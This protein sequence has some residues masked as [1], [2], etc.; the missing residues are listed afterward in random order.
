M[1]EI[2]T[3]LP[4]HGALIKNRSYRQIW[5]F[6]L[7]GK[8]Y[9]LKFYPRTR[10]KHRVHG[11]PAMKEFL[12]L[13]QLQ[14]ARIPAPR[15]ANAL[16]GYRLNG[17][18]GDALVIEG[19][20]PSI[21]FDDYL[22]D[23][24]LR[25]EPVPNRADLAFQ[26][27]DIVEKLG[28]AGLGH[29][30]LHL[31]NFLLSSGKLYLLDAYSIRPGGM[32]HK[33]VQYLGSSAGRFATRTELMRGWLRL[34]GVPP[35]PPRSPLAKRNL[36][37]FIESS[38]GENDWFGK[39]SI[40]DWHGHYFK[41]SKFARR[42]STVSGLTFSAADWQQA[43]PALWSELESNRLEK[44][45]TSPS[46]DVFAAKVQLGGAALD[47]VLKRPYKRYWYRYINE[48]G[49]GSRARR[50]WI[51]AWRLI[52]RNIPTAWP[53]LVLQKRKLGYVTDSILILERI[54]G[55]T[56]A[57]VEL[58]KIL[59][60]SDPCSC[61]APARS[62]ERSMPPGSRTLMPRQATGSSNPIRS[63]GRGPSSSTST[64]F[65]PAA[66]SRWASNACSAPC[67][68]ISNIPRRIRSHCAKG[69]HPI[70]GR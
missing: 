63:W 4:R 30:D 18:I 60:I 5:R 45:K 29:A 22:S 3:D 28:R 35:L 47:V 23:L 32:R 69:T 61:T 34:G 9:Y 11:N 68:N 50:A 38:L 58:N 46:G 7:A 36:R 24:E 44:I 59:T 54:P 67:A 39:I 20:E 27:V 8:P 19:I 14:N 40:G 31:G 48:I 70:H 25:G 33:D 1:E 15:A 55:P 66:G 64:A 16:V 51:K 17:N 13:Q 10:L 21:P 65:A 52:S 43:F 42:W 12:R 62:C 53:L 57:S 56:L 6:E 2:L 26:I 49:R 37:K 41:K